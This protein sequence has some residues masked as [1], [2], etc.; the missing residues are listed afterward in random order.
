MI[1]DFNGDGAD[2][3][4]RVQSAVN[5]PLPLFK[6]H[7][8]ASKDEKVWLSRDGQA[9]LMTSFQEPLGG[10][11]TVTYGPSAGTPGSR[12]PFNMQVVKS[13]TLDDGRGQ[14]A[15]RSTLTFNYEGGAWSREERQFLGFRTVKVNLP[16]IA[17]ESTCPQKVLTYSQAPACLGQVEVDQRFDGA[18]GLLSQ[19]WKSFTQ[20]TQLPLS[21]LVTATAS[22]IY[23]GGASKDLRQDFTY[24]LYGNTT[25]VIDYGVVDGGGDETVT[26]TSFSPNASGYLVSCPVQTLV[27]QGTSTTGALLSGTTLSYDGSAA[28]QPPSRCEKTQQDDWTGSN[29]ITTHRWS[30]DAYGNRGSETDGAGNTTATLYDGS[31]NLYPVETQ[32]P[33]YAADQRFRTQTAWNLACGQPSS[34]TDLNG[35]VSSFGYDALCRETYRR[36]PGGY[37]EWRGYNSLGQPGA[38]YNSVTSSPAGGQSTT[39]WSSDYFDGFGRSYYTA[40]NGPGGSHIDVVKAYDQRWNLAGQTAPFYSGDASYWTT[41]S[42][43]KLDRP[44][45]ATNPDGTSTST[46][47]GLGAAGSTDL[48]VTTLTDETGHRVIEATD[49]DGKR[50]KR[51]R[52]KDTAALTTQYLRDGLGRIVRVID[53]VGNQ[54][55]YGYDGLGRR[56]SV[57]DPDL[58]NWSYAYDNASRLTAQTDAKGQRAELGYDALSRLISK[59]VL[60]T[61]GTETTTNSYDQAR[62]GFFN[63]GQLTTA[64]RRVGDS[65]FTQAYD[66]DATGRLAQRRDL[67]VN[68]SDYAQGFDYWPDGSLKRKRLADGSSTGTYVYDTAGRLFSIGNANAPSSSE[69]AQYIAS[70]SYNARGQTTA[71]AYGGGVSTSFSYNEARGFLTRVLTRQNGQTLLD[72]SY[73]RNAKGLITDVSSPDSTRAWRYGYDALDRLVSADNQGGT[74]DDRSYGY[75]DADNLVANSALCGGA[76]LVYGAGAHPHAP[77]SICGTPVS[78]DANGNTLSYDPDGPGPLER[79]S[80]AYDGENRPVSVSAFGSLASFD[81]GP[82]GERTGKRFLGAK[83][84]YLGAEAEVLYGQAN[85]EGVVTSYLHADVRRE[86]SATDVMV[87]D[88]LASN[89]LVLRVGAGT[90]RADYGPFGQPLTSNGSVPLQGKGYI[91]ERY[92]PETG[93][94]YLHARYYD[95]LLARFLTPDTWDPDMA[96]V[97]TPERHGSDWASIRTAGLLLHQ[98]PSASRSTS[99]AASNPL[100]AKAPATGASV[101]QLENLT[102]AL[103]ATSPVALNQVPFVRVGRLVLRSIQTSPLKRPPKT[104]LS[105]V[106]SG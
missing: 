10:Q 79:R 23:S 78:Y 67:G 104:A 14:P 71:I 36:L 50:V 2:D 102:A 11:V 6:H 87:K 22:R 13:M 64:E 83:H 42:Y 97:D 39:R 91:N 60:A 96:G 29:W 57:S 19:D 73:T 98:S 41:L 7:D 21:C 46:A 94:Q 31:Y 49:A 27:Y 52:M 99:L 69:P 86:G 38:Q 103:A 24:D 68:G 4:G 65:R 51:I 82:D 70:A 105:V 77:V 26:L 30:Y 81:Y 35:Q 101:D 72:L 54:W 32:L 88:H 58:G 20:D 89:R 28:G 85:V 53:P 45:K 43:D 106:C 66:H 47:Y 12:L 62:S 8:P 16:C 100:S 90:T 74:V 92:D 84:F 9:D 37:E 44:V 34:K 56:T 76:A 48:L 5:P 17:G 55:A 95:P 33:T 25:Q 15:S 61:G 63:L 59:R 3:L 1:A 18:G 75:D 80:I 40:A 93:L